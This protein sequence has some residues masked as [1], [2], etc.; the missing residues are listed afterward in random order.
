MRF[1]G[2]RRDLELFEEDYQ[3]N[4]SE[5]TV[6]YGRRRIGKST[7]LE[8]FAQDKPCFFFQ[9]GKEKKQKQL[10]R[11][12]SEF[13][14]TLGNPPLI[15]K[16]RLT[17]WNEALMVLEQNLETLMQT[18]KGRKAV[19]IFDEFQWMC[20]GCPELLSD[21][22]RYWDKSWKK[23]GDLFL[24]LCGSSTS[25]M[26]GDVLSRKSPLFGRRTRS[27]HLNPFALDE[28][29]R[30]FPKRSHHEILETYACVGGVPKYLEVLQ[31]SRSLYQG[32]AREAF[33]GSGYFSKETDFVLGE[34][35]KETEHYYQVLMEL[36]K[37]PL[38]IAQL[39]KAIHIGSGQLA[40]YLERLGRLG[41]VDRLAPFGSKKT[42][43]KVR[44]QLKD[45]FLCF[46]FTFIAPAQRALM[47]QSEDPSFQAIAG[48]KWDSFMGKAFE[49]IC[50]DHADAIARAVG[51]QQV[52]DVGTYWQQAT[53]RKKG[54]QIDLIVECDAH[55]LLIC[56]CKWSRRS[57][58]TEAVDELKNRMSL[59]PNPKKQTLVP[60]L[61]SA[62]GF[63]REVKKEA[64]IRCV[65]LGDLFQ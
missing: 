59:F 1:I 36:A 54:V 45:Y 57:C 26:V 15:A 16:L 47:R 18:K 3:S 4:R 2:R 42:T 25:F 62:S 23:R 44:Y 37:Q 56:E 49:R 27:V 21:L 55:T 51:F 50:C 7:L 8:K 5:L 9:A 12:I 29:R 58:G 39:E 33:S 13:S 10:K 20:E 17:E 6:L 63:T 53:R 60:A 31:G 52:Q 41:F 14:Q 46:Y 22:Q 61:I 30:F 34:Q 35:L 28:V 48:K 19:I 38:S 65:D 32:L 40:Y 11:F 64:S 24:I 43:K